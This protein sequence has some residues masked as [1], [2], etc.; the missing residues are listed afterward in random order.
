[1]PDK[2]IYYAMVDDLSSRA[3]PASVFRR[4][5]TEVGGRRDELFTKDLIWKR[6]FLLASAERGDTQYDFVEISEE[7]AHQ[8]MDRIRAEET[9]AP[10]S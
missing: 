3:R 10:G 7:E 8:I 5:Y 4:T 2:V 1:M 6:S 9:G